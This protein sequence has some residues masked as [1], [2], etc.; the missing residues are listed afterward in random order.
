MKILQYGLTVRALVVLEGKIKGLK[1]IRNSKILN[2]KLKALKFKIPN[3][4]NF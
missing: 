3:V 4:L 2:L 1:K